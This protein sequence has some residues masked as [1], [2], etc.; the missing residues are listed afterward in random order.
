MRTLIA[1]ASL[2]IFTS[3]SA[4]FDSTKTDSIK[5][6]PFDQWDRNAAYNTG[7]YLKKYTAMQYTGIGLTLAGATVSGIGFGIKNAVVPYVGLGMAGIGFIL[8]LIAP[9]YI[10]KAGNFLIYIGERNDKK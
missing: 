10:D 6:R 7:I 4:Q 8:Q 3:V 1:I 2:F 5:I 9:A